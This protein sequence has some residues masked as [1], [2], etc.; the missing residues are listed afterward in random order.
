[1]F[2]Y[3]SLQYIQLRKVTISDT[4]DI[5]TYTQTNGHTETYKHTN[6]LT[7]TGN[8]FYSWPSFNKY[9]EILLG[10]RLPKQ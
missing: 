6:I 2:A 7:F 3:Y 1:M 10:T 5:H 4:V 9:I 8:F